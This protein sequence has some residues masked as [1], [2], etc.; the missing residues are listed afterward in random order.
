MINAKRSVS[1]KR[2]KE[3]TALVPLVMLS[4]CA[5]VGQ[6]FVFSGP[7]SIQAGKT[8]RAE[9][10]ERYGEPF[11][12]G[13]DS[14]NLKWTYGYYKYRL[15]GDSDTKDLDVTFDKNGV[16][17]SYTYSTSVPDEKKSLS[18]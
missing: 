1:S 13:Y 14:G 2:L 4:S 11:R 10:S 3:G 7:D 18:K 9:I 16:V 17:K 15:F 12:A 6:P 8:T 5:T